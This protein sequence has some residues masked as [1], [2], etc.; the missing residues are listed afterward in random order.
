MRRKINFKYQNLTRGSVHKIVGM[1]QTSAW[2][3]REDFDD[4]RSWF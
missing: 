1:L 4:N 2:Y 3:K